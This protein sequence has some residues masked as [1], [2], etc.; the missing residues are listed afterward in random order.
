MHTQSL[1]CT[2]KPKTLSSGRP[3][4]KSR[5]RDRGCPVPNHGSLEKVCCCAGCAP[6]LGTGAPTKG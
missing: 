6:M 3:M 1:P 5:A 4:H 2:P